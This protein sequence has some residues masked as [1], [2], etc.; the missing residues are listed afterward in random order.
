MTTTG[1]DLLQ[2]T[3]QAR[4]Y[5]MYGDGH[6]LES[7]FEVAAWNWNGVMTLRGVS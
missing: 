6:G 1:C 5:M 3:G 4:V 7:I 2:G